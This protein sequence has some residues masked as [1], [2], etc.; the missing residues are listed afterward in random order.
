LVLLANARNR[1]EPVELSAIA[2]NISVL[3][4]LPVCPA[5]GLLNAML[6]RPYFVSEFAP[7]AA[8]IA[9]SRPLS[10]VHVIPPSLDLKTPL[11]GSAAQSPAVTSAASLSGYPIAPYAV[12][13]VESFVSNAIPVAI[14]IEG[15][16]GFCSFQCIPPSVERQNPH[17]IAGVP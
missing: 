11:Q 1:F 7:S 6:I 5:S 4:G 14:S 13:P 15:L 16:A 8:L 12:S 2:A 9:V 17:G 3:A 10:R